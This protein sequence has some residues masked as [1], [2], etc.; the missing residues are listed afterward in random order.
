MYWI[1][2]LLDLSQLVTVLAFWL[3]IYF[4]Y[5]GLFA[6]AIEQHKEEI[7]CSQ[8]IDDT[9]GVAVGHRKVGE[10]LC[11][12]GSYQ[13]AITHQNKH[14]EVLTELIHKRSNIVK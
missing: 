1:L 9:I 13:K 6:E 14:L 7:L 5:L 2:W 10:C 11:E 3:C 8:K 4:S 12:L